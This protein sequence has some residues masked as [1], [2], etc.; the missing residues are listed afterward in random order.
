MSKPGAKVVV[1]GSLNVDY[2]ALVEQL[3]SA[4]E[5]VPAT[6]LIKRFGGKGANQ[7]VAAAR[8]GASV[9]LIG[10][11]GEDDEG[12]VYCESLAAEGIE[13]TGISTTLKSLTGTALI[14]V[15]SAA[16]NTI[17]VAAG[18]NGELKRAAIKAQQQRIQSAN[19]LLLQ[20]EIP[21]ESVVEA[22]RIANRA[23]VPVVFNPS[24]LREGFPWGKYHIET[25]IVNAGEAESIFRLNIKNIA[26][27]IPTWRRALLK[28]AVGQ[29][30]ITRGAKAT[31]YVNANELEEIP[32]LQVRPVD[33]VGAGDA[34]A[35]AFTAHS[36]GGAEII[37]AI[38]RANCVGALATLKQGAQE[39][40]PSLRATEMA[41]RT[42]R[43]L[44]K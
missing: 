1:V 39:A 7:A 19:A 21:L 42:V 20:Q 43:R 24:P 17:I 8:Q 3:P 29:L 26:R 16:E 30:I 25:L 23:R 31:L 18:A 2:I 13:V 35:G 40:I 38:Q 15:D 11:V 5:T 14:A 6:E 41:F 12:R 27:N 34:F 32:T 33:T 22:V 28:R 4:G 9:S 10:C 37:S 36:A 44:C